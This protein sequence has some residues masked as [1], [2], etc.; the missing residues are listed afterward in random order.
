MESETG[1]RREGRDYPEVYPERRNVGQQEHEASVNEKDGVW[2]LKRIDV[3]S[4]LKIFLNVYYI[5]I[6]S[7]S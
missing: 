1:R 3:L 6:K 4:P 2:F 5:C 7:C